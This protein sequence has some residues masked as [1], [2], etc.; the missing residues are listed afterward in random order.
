MSVG[1]ELQAARAKA[2]LT[3]E[4]VAER[5][6][7]RRTVIERME[8]DDFSLCGGDVY[9]RGHLRTVATVV[10]ADPDVL[11]AEFDRIHEPHAPSATEVFESETGTKRERRGPNWTAAMAA[12][13]VVV[14]LIAV[15]QLV[16]G[17]GSPAPA[18]GPS[19]SSSLGVGASTPPG[20]SPSA[21]STGASPS[22]TVLAQVPP[23]AQGVTVRIDVVS[24]HSWIS[25][26]G[27]GK[28]LYEGLLSAGT[29]KVLTD[30][31]LVKLLVGNAA[32]LRLTVN[33]V[34]IG[35]PG[36]PGAVVHLS[37][38]PGDPTAAG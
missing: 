23:S 8:A 14:A 37:F 36:G 33:G 11:V 5:T 17:G 21:A 32:A 27:S 16:R 3:V 34:D 38:G 35:S 26:T 31:N 25:A 7:I 10:G 29:V 15:F 6:M 9:A 1:S 19:A 20:T 2:G 24:G 30:P 28:Q 13:L 18:A 4:N 22:P 12:A